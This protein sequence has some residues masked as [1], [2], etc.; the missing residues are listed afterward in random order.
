MLRARLVLATLL[1]WS[2][3]ACWAS[4]DGLTGGE[5]VD[6][7]AP[8]AGVHD[9]TVGDANASDASMIDSAVTDSSAGDAFAIDAPDVVT[10]LAD[11]S[12]D[13]RAPS[14]ASTCTGTMAV[15]AT[16]GTQLLASTWNASNGWA[17]PT[18]T[19]QQS[20]NG[21]IAMASDSRGFYAVFESG[22]AL[23]VLEFQSGNWLPLQTPQ[24]ASMLLPSPFIVATGTAL[25]AFVRG[26]DDGFRDF[27]QDST[28]DAG[29]TWA[30]PST[31]PG[32]PSELPMSNDAITGALIGGVPYALLVG[33]NLTG[34]GVFTQMFADSW[35][36]PAFLNVG[37]SAV[38]PELVPLDGVG[39]DNDELLVFTPSDT[40]L[41]TSYLLHNKFNGGWPSQGTVISP[42]VDAVSPISLAPI[43]GGNAVLSY[44]DQSDGGMTPTI[45]FFNGTS[46]GSPIPI[47]IDG[48]PLAASSALVAAQGVCGADAVLAY[49]ELGTGVITLNVNTTGTTFAS[50]A[51]VQ[52]TTSA[53]ATGIAS[54]Q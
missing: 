7:G 9:A 36:T 39:S 48:Q 12:V 42:L 32:N 50:P 41:T 23:R 15:V 26:T 8:D 33:A 17:A 18:T 53:T 4:F 29:T 47:T 27:L 20:D 6:A 44:I 40:T 30:T 24:G 11:S 14:D 51:I 38:P 28:A 46:W 43:A 1:P 3:G 45:I 19:T 22:Q 49:A 13:A 21:G 5:P 2:V 31:N 10:I 34:S 35:Q 54:K 37:S 52:G 25:H 16:S